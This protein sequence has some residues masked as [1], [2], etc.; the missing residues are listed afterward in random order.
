MAS[1]GDTLVLYGLVRTDLASMTRGMVGAH[2]MHA[3]QHATTLI[4]KRKVFGELWNTKYQ[5]WCAQTVDGFGTALTL[6]TGR[7]ETLRGLVDVA[8]KLGFPA[9]VTHDPEY[10]LRDGNFVHLIPVDTGGW[11]FGAK[12]ELSVLLGSF[13]LCV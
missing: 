9:A 13:S 1:P 8:K 2:M 5:E 12:S 6:D 10:P 4:E 3:A 11:I 7:I